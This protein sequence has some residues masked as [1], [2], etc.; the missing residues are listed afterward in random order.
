M[1][2]LCSCLEVPLNRDPCRAVSQEV[3]PVE[4]FRR[5][6]HSDACVYMDIFQRC[7]GVQ[8]A[9]P[10]TQPLASSV[11]AQPLASQQAVNPSTNLQV[12]PLSTF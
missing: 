3:L 8:S 9:V 7:C 2:V 11:A 4:K 5:A 10:Q 1:K 12:T 6:R